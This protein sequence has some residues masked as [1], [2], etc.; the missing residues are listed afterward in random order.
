MALDLKQPATPAQQLCQ[1]VRQCTAQRKHGPTKSSLPLGG[2]WQATCC[3]P[4]LWLERPAA[5][6]GLLLVVDAYRPQRHGARSVS[7][8]MIQEL[9]P[10]N[11]IRGSHSRIAG[12]CRHR[13]RNCWHRS[14][15][16]LNGFVYHSV[17]CGLRN[18]RA[19]LQQNSGGVRTTRSAVLSAVTSA[20]TITSALR[21]ETDLKTAPA[22]R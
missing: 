7:W 2:H 9:S 8:E 19:V 1:R 20:P 14:Q 5:R 10:Q 13:N 6:N 12:V 17:Q 22:C 21:A 18:H 11:L 3:G 16:P 4:E 15:S